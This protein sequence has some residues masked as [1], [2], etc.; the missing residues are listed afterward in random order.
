VYRA[1]IQFYNAFNIKD[2]LM[3]TPLGEQSGWYYTMTNATQD[4]AKV[5]LEIV[6]RG[7][8]EFYRSEQL[9]QVGYLGSTDQDGTKYGADVGYAWCSE[10]YSTIVDQTLGSMGTRYNTTEMATY[11]EDYGRDYYVGE[12]YSLTQ[13]LALA[14]PGDY[15]GEA[16]GDPD[17]IHHSAMFLAYDTHTGYIFT[18]DGNGDGTM[19]D[20]ELATSTDKRKGGSEVVV[21]VRE[22]S[23]IALWG[24]L[25]P[26]ML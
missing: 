13:V 17:D 22:T 16:S 12:D 24:K 3:G 15:L 19:V 1:R 25:R 10:F 18:L 5:R 4:F 21:K 20:P 7:L 14:R 23:V 11:F 9:G 8:A 6:L 26:S 2:R